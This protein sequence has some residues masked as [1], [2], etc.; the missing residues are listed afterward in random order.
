MS[1]TE[2]PFFVFCQQL[3][4]ENMNP[5]RIRM[6]LQAL[7]ATNGDLSRETGLSTYYLSRLLNGRVVRPTSRT[8]HRLAHG[9]R[10]LITERNI[11]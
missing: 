11:V 6:I 10:E 4:R 8:R 3:E 2:G 5:L 7:E 1:R 9:L